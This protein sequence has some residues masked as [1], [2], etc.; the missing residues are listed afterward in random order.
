MWEFCL[1]SHRY[2][3]ICICNL[4]VH[5]CLCVGKLIEE[6]E[7][8]THAYHVQFSPKEALDAFESHPAFLAVEAYCKGSL[9]V[10]VSHTSL[11]G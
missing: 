1:Q 2:V 4:C 6:K 9:P 5:V 3:Y 8:C 11:T 10:R 7:G